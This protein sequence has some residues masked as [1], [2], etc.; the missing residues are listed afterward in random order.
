VH[1]V[2]LGLI[3]NVSPI[4]VGAQQSTTSTNVPV[5][6]SETKMLSQAAN[7]AIFVYDAGVDACAAPISSDQILLPLGTAFVVGI[8]DKS[9]TN[10]ALWTGFK[11][12]V[13]AKHVLDKRTDIVIRLNMTNGR[14]FKCYPMHLTDSG[15]GENL[16]FADSGVDLAAVVLPDI[17]DTDPTVIDVSNIIDEG[18]M[19]SVGIGV[20]TQVFTVGYIFGYSGQTINYPVTKFGQLSVMTDE[21]WFFSPESKLMEQADVVQ[22]PNTPGLSGAPVITHGMEFDTNPFR[23]R[24]LPPY[25]VGV[26]KALLLAP[27]NNNRWI[28]QDV[29]LIEPGANLRALM[30]EIEM[31]LKEEGKDVDVE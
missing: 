20:G 16:V 29:A 22:L 8:K 21:H 10:S 5:T 11:F 17:P 6:S 31:K 30:H 3:L 7:T 26:V 14:G 2:I 25:L 28:S 12:L 1:W 4:T 19:R 27:V 24:A 18:T 15:P 13:T 9:A 23:Y